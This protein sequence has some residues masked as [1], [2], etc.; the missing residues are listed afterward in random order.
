[1]PPHC[2]QLLVGTSGWSYD[3]GDFY[4]GDLASRRRLEYHARHFR[5]VEVNSSF[6]HL[7][8]KTTYEK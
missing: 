6:Y 7:L 8:R 2:G 3:W 5:T 4:P 1:M